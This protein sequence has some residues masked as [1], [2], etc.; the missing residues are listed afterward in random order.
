MPEASLVAHKREQKGKQAAKQLRRE[1]L[2]PGILYGPGEEP[3]MLTIN[4]K[5]LLNLLHAFGRNVIVNLGVDTSKKKI[6]AFIYDIQHDPI[7]GDII[8][9]DL[10]HINLKEKIRI[11][12]P[13][14]LT[15]VPEGVKNEGGILEHSLHTLEILCLPV[16]IPERITIDV[17][18]LHLGDAVHIG[19]IATTDFEFI[20]EKTST[21]VHVIA[22][23]IAKVVEEAPAEEGELPAE[24]EVIGEEE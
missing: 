14:Q 15:G 4:M 19:D 5:E 23:K 18:G 16:N 9:V 11:S 2:I 17:S 3:S 21:V 7:S 6:K 1:G 24:P 8:H 12:V 10:K 22:P 13:V 20:S